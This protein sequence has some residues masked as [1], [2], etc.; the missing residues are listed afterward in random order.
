MTCC[1]GISSSGFL[2][3]RLQGLCK[4]KRGAEG[5]FFFF[6]DL[7]SLEQANLNAKECNP[8]KELIGSPTERTQ[9]ADNIGTESEPHWMDS[10]YPFPMHLAYMPQDKWMMEDPEVRTHNFQG[11]L[12]HSGYTVEGAVAQKHS[13]LSVG[14][15]CL[16]NHQ[17]M[18]DRDVSP[19]FPPNSADLQVPSPVRTTAGPGLCSFMADACAPF[20]SSSGVHNYP[21]CSDHCPVSAAA[22]LHLLGESMSLIGSHLEETNKRVCMSGSLSLF[23][24][25]LL[26]ALAPLMCLT[27]QIPELTS[28]SEHTLTSTLENVAYVMPGL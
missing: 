26:C 23:L 17:E 8:H 20:G 7:N 24:D 18:A 6:M 2:W 12:L 25:S 3:A 10:S 4:P 21:C 15:L 11:N 1:S 9:H 14:L 16:D 27:T 5:V 22:H 19:S 28:C 13:N